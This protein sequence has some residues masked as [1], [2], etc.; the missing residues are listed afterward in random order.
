MGIQSFALEFPDTILQLDLATKQYQVFS[1][2]SISGYAH[3]YAS[4]CNVSSSQFSAATAS[5]V[6]NAALVYVGIFRATLMQADGTTRVLE[7]ID[8]LGVYTPAQF[9]QAKAAEL[10]AREQIIRDN[11]A[12]RGLTLKNLELVAVKTTGIS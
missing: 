6:R 4:M 3:D 10:A 12:Q 2:T 1:A 5:T 9:E 11:F 8:G 7:V